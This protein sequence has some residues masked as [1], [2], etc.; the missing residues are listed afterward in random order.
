MDTPELTRYCVLQTAVI[1]EL[2]E[3]SGADRREPGLAA[4]LKEL[5]ALTMRLAHRCRSAVDYHET[6]RGKAALE[7]ARNFAAAAAAAADGELVEWTEK[8]WSQEQV[9]AGVF[10]PTDRPE[11]TVRRS[12]NPSGVAL[13]SDLKE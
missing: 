5:D 12:L 3:L 11:E 4:I 1:N 9:A 6:S 2:L 7:D 8:R 13:L 10:K